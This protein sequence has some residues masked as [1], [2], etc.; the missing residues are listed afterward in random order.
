MLIVNE[1]LDGHQFYGCDAQRFDVFDDRLRPESSV[2]ASQSRRHLRVQ[3]CVPT[4]MRLVN[5]RAIP[6]SYL[7]ACLALPVEIRV[8]DD[9]FGNERRA[10]SFVESQIVAGFELIAIAGG[11]PFQ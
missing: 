11:I 3:H 7:P 6:R 2:S 10:I 5:D 4:Q 1:S 8:D 9:T